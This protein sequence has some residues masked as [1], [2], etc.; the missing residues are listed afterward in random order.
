MQTFKGN[1]PIPDSCSQ[2]ME[3]KKKDQSEEVFGRET[4]GGISL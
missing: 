2:L 3:E 1:G 4:G